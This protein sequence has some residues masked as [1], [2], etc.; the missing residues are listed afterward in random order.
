MPKVVLIKGNEWK[1]ELV[2]CIKGKAG[3]YG[4][5]LT[6]LASVAGINKRT[7]SNRYHQPEF[8]TLEQIVKL[9]KRLKL[10]L[11]V[12]ENGVRCRMKLDGG[13]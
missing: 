4:L 10:E 13:V 7:F 8:F 9:C 6:D 11:V 5:D 3:Y 1:E 2:K 12:D